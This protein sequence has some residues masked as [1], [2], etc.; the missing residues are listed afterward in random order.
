MQLYTCAKLTFLRIYYKR[1]TIKGLLG[2]T[3]ISNFGL[4]LQKLL[5]LISHKIYRPIIGT[6]VDRVLLIIMN[7]ISIIHNVAS[8]HWFAPHLAVVPKNLLATD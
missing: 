7:Y 3:L 6:I 1:D 2:K 8:R 4:L 5:K